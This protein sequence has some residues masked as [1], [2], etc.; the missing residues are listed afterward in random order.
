MDEMQRTN[1]EPPRILLVDDDV[2]LAG[3]LREFLELQGMQVDILHDAE[4]ALGA[5]DVSAS[6][7]FMPGSITS[8]TIAS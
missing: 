4:A 3:M 8:R 7:P 6:K 1:D 5:V 2:P